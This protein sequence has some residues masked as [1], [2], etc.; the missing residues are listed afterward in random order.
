M[1]V[2]YCNSVENVFSNAVMHTKVV[3]Y[4]SSPYK[5]CQYQQCIDKLS[6]AIVHTKMVYCNGACKNDN[7]KSAILTVLKK[8][9]NCNIA[10]ILPMCYNEDK[11]RDFRKSI[12]KLPIS[13]VHRKVV[14]A[15]GHRK[16]LNLTATYKTI[17]ESA[18]KSYQLP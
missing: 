1:H 16:V 15:I 4:H 13:I 3:F 5:S 7:F 10:Y 2:V 6:I 11:I 9:P 12:Q 17:F 14:I 8:G 18:Y